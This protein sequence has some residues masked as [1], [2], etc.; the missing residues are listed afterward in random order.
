ME[1]LQ[2]F[3]HES[4]VPN[5]T[6]TSI[7][8]ESN[9]LNTFA[10][11]HYNGML[12][13]VPRGFEFPKVDALVAFQLWCCGDPSSSIPPF[14]ILRPHDMPSTS[15]RKRLSD[16]R[17]LNK[18]IEDACKSKGIWIDNPT[19]IEANEM[20]LRV[21]EILPSTDATDGRYRSRQAR[22][23]TVVNLMRKNLQNG[24]R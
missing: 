5:R 10:Y 7:N 21:A 8:A 1:Q 3:M 11:H 24:R 20:F 17:F 15:T 2:T 4:T 14:R 22:W 12:H 6:D 13:R 16:F 18:R 9:Q 23:R 19:V